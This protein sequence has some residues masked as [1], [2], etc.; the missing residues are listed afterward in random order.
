MNAEKKLTIF[1]NVVWNTIGSLT[2]L[3]C[4]WLLTLVVVRVSDDMT[5]AGNLSLA[6]SVT[7]IFY[8]L[9]C[10]QVRPYLVSDLNNHYKINEYSVFRICTCVASTLMCA[11]YLCLYG[12]NRQQFICIMIYMLYKVG[13]A[14]VDLLHAYEQRKSR[15]DIGGIS[16]F[17]RGIISVVTFGVTLKYT[18]NLNLSITVMAVCTIGFIIVFDCPISYKFEKYISKIELKRMLKMLLE[19]FPLAIGSF[20]STTAANLP[21]QIL[22]TK[23][24]SEVLGIYSTVATPAI[25]VQVAATYVFNP[26][27]TKLA[28]LYNENKKKDFVRL[29]AKISGVLVC[30]SLVC[31]C[32]A[33]VLGKWGLEL[34][35]GEKVK[36]HVYLLLPVIYYTCLNAFVMFFWNLLIVMRKLKLL[37]I[38]GAS[39]LLV[40]VSIM[41]G[42]IS[43]Y[44]MNGVSY[45]LII[46]SISLI[47]IMLGVIFNELYRKGKMPQQI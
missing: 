44:E 11:I 7:N 46:Y 37:L 32:G 14:W 39:G 1:E 25:I 16:L 38:I 21:R 15:M 29:I 45:T 27:L 22:E 41:S 20:M 5:N 8:S 33:F 40:C 19:F 26:V 30:I 43:V 2:Y 28:T 13:E 23:M 42:M 36:G 24:G 4:Q 47:L 3:I 6:M 35:Y 17:V 34:L 10:F 12:Y 18:D 9:A 31:I